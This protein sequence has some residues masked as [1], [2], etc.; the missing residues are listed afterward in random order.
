[1]VWTSAGWIDQGEAA[2]DFYGWHIPKELFCK[3]CGA[4]INP[5]PQII[6]GKRMCGYP[7]DEWEM[8]FEEIWWECPR[9]MKTYNNIE[10]FAVFGD[11]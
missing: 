4:K 1:M 3:E 5:N 6:A 11:Y 7:G 9:C 8:D 10:E 2:D